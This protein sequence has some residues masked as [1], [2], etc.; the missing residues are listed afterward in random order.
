MDWLVDWLATSWWGHAGKFFSAADLQVGSRLTFNGV[1]FLLLN[2]DDYT[3]THM[4]A[5]PRDFPFVSDDVCVCVY[6]CVCWRVSVYV[7]VCVCVC[8]CVQSLCVRVGSENNISASVY[9]TP[10]LPPPTRSGLC[11]C[12]GGCTERPAGPQQ[13]QQQQ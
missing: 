10:P 3:L 5:S 11:P 6:V 1:P 2:A 13:Q 8:V 9:H 12:C 7:C 4:E